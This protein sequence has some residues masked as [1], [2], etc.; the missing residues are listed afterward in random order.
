M[1]GIG[2]LKLRDGF[3]NG[4]YDARGVHVRGMEDGGDQE[5]RLAEKWRSR[6]ERLTF[7]YPFVST[8]L[9][10]I[11]RTYEGEATEYDTQ[12]QARMRMGR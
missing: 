6:A 5:R 2:S 12:A 1:E 4:V 7:D 8:V 10:G 9:D 3:Q 11:A